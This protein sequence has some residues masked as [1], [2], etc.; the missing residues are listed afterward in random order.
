MSS[1]KNEA[2]RVLGKA[3]LEPLWEHH[4][5]DAAG[6]IGKTSSTDS[7]DRTHFVVRL[8]LDPRKVLS[9][10]AMGEAL[11]Y[12]IVN[13]YLHRVEEQANLG[14]ISK[15]QLL[16][17]AIAHEIGHLLLGN[18][19]HSSHGLMAARW[20]KAELARLTQGD[21][22][23]LAAE[24]ER[25]R[26]EVQRRHQSKEFL[27]EDSL[28]EIWTELFPNQREAGFASELFGGQVQRRLV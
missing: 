5:T 19:S 3:G 1:A 12:R 11:S 27:T 17:H 8:L 13:V 24:V 26:A 9:K 4:S 18:N 2:S 15:A 23:F 16:G 6:Q 21:L 7:W 22:Q 14:Q 20:S 10:R 28:N 25:I